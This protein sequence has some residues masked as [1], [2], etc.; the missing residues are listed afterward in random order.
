MSEAPDPVV[1]TA[2]RL[3]STLERIGDALVALDADTLLETEETLGQLL[4][5]LA[6]SGE[7]QNKPALEASVN[8]ARQALLR[9]RRLGASFT[10]LAG[11]RLRMRS[12]LETYGHHGG[13]L[14][15]AVSGASVKVS[16]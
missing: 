14:E 12:G 8:R 11:A 13:Y 5:A 7:V 6:A 9:S 16:A 4:A 15:P 1:E 2:E 10:S 3:C